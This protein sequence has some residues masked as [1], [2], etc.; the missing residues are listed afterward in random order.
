[1]TF[2]DLNIF[3]FYSA[4]QLTD[5]EKINAPLVQAYQNI[6]QAGDF[7][8]THLFNGRYENTYIP[9]AN[10]PALQPVV[11]A[12]LF[13]SQKMLDQTELKYGFWFN[14]M[15]P[16]QTTS[17]HN[18]DEMDELISCV[19]YIQ[20]ETN[21]GDF[22][23]HAKGQQYQIKPEAGKML[24]FSPA[25]DHAVTENTSPNTRLSVAFNIGPA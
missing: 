9:L 1:M 16:G 21:S 18:H 24:F 14:E 19:Y 4:A 20:C 12:V 13:Y 11:D 7:N 25:L 17:L 22:V 8:A 3:D 23:L 6:K 10:I 5:A 2:F 15:Q